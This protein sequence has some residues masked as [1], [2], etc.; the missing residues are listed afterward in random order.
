MKCI[1]CL[2]YQQC[3]SPSSFPLVLLFVV[4]VMSLSSLVVK[5]P[6]EYARGT[7][8][9]SV[10]SPTTDQDIEVASSVVAD[11]VAQLSPC[12]SSSSSS[13]SQSQAQ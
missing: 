9:L 8:R 2:S 5:V 6:L 7:L 3:V 4:A 12:I 10:G 1:V 13:S 11:A